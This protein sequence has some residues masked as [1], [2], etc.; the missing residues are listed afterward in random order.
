MKA[1]LTFL[2]VCALIISASCAKQT[3]ELE[4]NPKYTADDTP[5]ATVRSEFF[6]GG[7]AQSKTVNYSEL[8]EICTSRGFK[9]VSKVQT[10]Q[11][12]IDVLLNVIS[13]GIFYPYSKNVFCSN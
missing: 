9:K 11:T 6:V 2:I 10:Y 13:L 4:P 12:G 7:I 3:F 1:K 5:D 8:Q